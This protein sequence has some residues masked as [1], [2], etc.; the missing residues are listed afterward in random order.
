LKD[1]E[2]DPLDAFMDEVAKTKQDEAP[3]KKVPFDFVAC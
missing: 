3:K 2:Y 1:Q